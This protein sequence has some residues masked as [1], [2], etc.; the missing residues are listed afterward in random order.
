MSGFSFVARGANQIQDAIGR[1]AIDDPRWEPAI[2]SGSD[3]TDE[4]TPEHTLSE[5]TDQPEPRA[6]VADFTD[7]VDTRKWPTG[8]RLIVRREPLHPGAQRSLFPAFEYRYWGHWTDSHMAAPET[9]ADM[10]AHARV[11]GHI[12]RLKASGANRF[13]FTD[14]T[15]NRAWLAL[16]TWADTVVRWFQLLCLPDTRLQDAR[17]KT[18]RWW[19]WHTPARLVR[20]ARRTTIRIPQTWPT[21]P[22]ITTCYQ[23]IQ[24]I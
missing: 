17:P 13:P 16:V 21:G 23:H 24:T 2:P 8:T 5:D 9:D 7:L 15:A 18:L 12:A 22:L 20:H 19:L 11:G 3:Q 14:L 6:W 4:Q 1:V 10:R